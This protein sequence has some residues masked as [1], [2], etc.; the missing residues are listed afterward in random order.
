MT[1]PGQAIDVTKHTEAIIW[2]ESTAKNMNR[3]IKMDDLGIIQT[4]I[5]F[6]CRE[7]WLTTKLFLHHGVQWV[8][9]EW[10]TKDS[11]KSAFLC[12]PADQ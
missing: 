12:G 9:G 8:V 2:D 3:Y 1:A 6:I 5:I 4:K 11:S 7:M 10:A